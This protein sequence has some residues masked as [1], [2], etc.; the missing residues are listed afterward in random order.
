M[1]GSGVEIENPAWTLV[2][3]LKSSDGSLEV[4]QQVLKQ[5]G[6]RFDRV[7]DF[8]VGRDR[9]EVVALELFWARH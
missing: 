8:E 9:V 4:W 7:K 1:L 5:T 3:I 6:W 2:V